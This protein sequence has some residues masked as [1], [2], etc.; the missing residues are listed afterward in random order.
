MNANTPITSV[1]AKRDQDMLI[2][3]KRVPA[4]SGQRFETRNPAT[5][6][7]LAN[8]AQGGAEAVRRP[9]R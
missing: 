5:G 7:L 8:V 2:S 4:V 1:I 6:E 9:R 3:G